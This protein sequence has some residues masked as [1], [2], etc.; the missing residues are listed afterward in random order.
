MDARDALLKQALD[1]LY[2]WNHE[3]GCCEGATAETEQAIYAHLTAA[4]V[5]VETYAES[6]ARE[7]RELEEG[8]AA[9]RAKEAGA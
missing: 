6:E 7:D 2:W 8:M 5:P 3:H 9:Q 1:A 4:G